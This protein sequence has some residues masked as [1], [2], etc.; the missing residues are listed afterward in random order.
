MQKL[1][2]IQYSVQQQSIAYS[3]IVLGNLLS[4]AE[5]F[6]G[7]QNEQYGYYNISKAKTKEELKSEFAWELYCFQLSY[8]QLL[9]KFHLQDYPY[10]KEAPKEKILEDIEKWESRIETEKDFVLFNAMENIILGKKNDIDFD[11]LFEEIDSSQKLNPKKL[12]DI[13]GPLNNTLDKI[14]ENANENE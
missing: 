13:I 10:P 9:K 4:S 12:K 7:L 14:V 3:Y 5:N 11:E 2:Q 6:V 8:K 1:K